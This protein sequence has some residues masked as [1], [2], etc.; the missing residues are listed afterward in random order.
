MLWPIAVRIEAKAGALHCFLNKLP[1]ISACYRDGQIACQALPRQYCH[2]AIA[3]PRNFEIV[4]I[5]RCLWRPF[6]GSQA[7]IGATCS[8]VAVR[9]ALG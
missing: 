6:V 8:G 2:D 9:T 1:P 7:N 5:P 4:R 3:S